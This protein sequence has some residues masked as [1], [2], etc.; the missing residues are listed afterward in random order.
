MSLRKCYEVNASAQ[1]H[2]SLTD[3]SHPFLK[4]PSKVCCLFQRLD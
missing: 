3:N 4:R 1:L 2:I